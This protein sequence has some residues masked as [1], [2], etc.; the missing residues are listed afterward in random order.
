MQE[1]MTGQPWRHYAGASH[2]GA[3]VKSDKY[4]SNNGAKTVL[5][6]KTKGHSSN[7]AATYNVELRQLSLFHGTHT[8]YVIKVFVSTK[9][10]KSTLFR[11]ITYVR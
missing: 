2:D 6:N 4:F 7:C 3:I 5:K 8:F 9:K 10:F 1:I 11:F